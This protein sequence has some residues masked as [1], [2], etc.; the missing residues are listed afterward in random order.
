MNPTTSADIQSD[1][2]PYALFFTGNARV[3]IAYTAYDNEHSK[4]VDSIAAI[5][6]QTL[7]DASADLEDLPDYVDIRTG[8]T[9]RP[10]PGQVRFSGF[11]VDSSG[12]DT[13]DIDVIV[14]Y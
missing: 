3:Y 13:E 14:T 11:S 10:S 6:T 4:Y 7:L 12:D 9:T 8:L 1:R 2:W 5:N